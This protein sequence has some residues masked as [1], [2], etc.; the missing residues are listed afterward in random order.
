[1]GCCF[2]RNTSDIE[3]A[4]TT[5]AAVTSKLGKHGENVKIQVDPASGYFLVKGRGSA[6][7]TCVLECDSAYWEV[8]IGD[9]PNGV[10]VGIKR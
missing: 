10:C 8:K 5:N 1:M 9:N 4:S 7:G 3:I 2:G 6:V